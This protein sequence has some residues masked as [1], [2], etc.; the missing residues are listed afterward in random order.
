MFVELIVD[1]ANGETALTHAYSTDDDHFERELGFHQFI[2]K[3]MTLKYKYD[4][5]LEK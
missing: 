4:R 5:K 3:T 2:I 1:V